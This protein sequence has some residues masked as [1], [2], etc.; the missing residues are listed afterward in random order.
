VWRTLRRAFRQAADNFVEAV[1]T[2]IAVTGGLI[3]VVA[4]LAA[5]FWLL[6]AIWR[7]TRRRRAA[8]Q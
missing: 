5:A 7:R 4:A 1:A 3:P 8:A 2:V 6:R